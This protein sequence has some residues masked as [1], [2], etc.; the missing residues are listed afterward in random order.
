MGLPS[1]FQTH[2]GFIK[3]RPNPAPKAGFFFARTRLSGLGVAQVW[4]QE[5]WR[6]GR[7]AQSCGGRKSPRPGS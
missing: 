6:L 3:G 1:W 7:L 4:W 2:F 5:F